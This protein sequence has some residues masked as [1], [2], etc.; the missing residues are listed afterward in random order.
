MQGGE[1]LSL[2]QIRALLEA[3]QEIRFAGHSRKEVYEWVGR[4][5]REH[6]Y[7]KQG[8][9]AKGLVRALYWQD[10]GTEPGAGYE[11]GW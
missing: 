10:D 11:I 4:T 5:L 7:A 3:S 6:N 9:E 8:R 1:K 2:D